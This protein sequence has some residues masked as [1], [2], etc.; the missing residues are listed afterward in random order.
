MVFLLVF[1]TII[2]GKLGWKW[3]GLF[4]GISVV[5]NVLELIIMITSNSG[6]LGASGVIYG[7]MA[8]C[9]L[10]APMNRIHMLFLPI[11]WWVAFL[12]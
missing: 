12:L 7:F 10:W 2:E 1:G 8:I 3:L 6:S 5:A 9:M 4:L 11:Q